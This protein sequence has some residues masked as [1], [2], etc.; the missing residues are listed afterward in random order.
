M[1]SKRGDR[2][3]TEAFPISNASLPVGLFSFRFPYAAGGA[4]G[5]DRISLCSQR[6]LLSHWTVNRTGDLLTRR[7]PPIFSSKAVGEIPGD[8]FTQ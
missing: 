7:L 1:Q 8:N 3:G 5:V 4:S 2:G 6:R